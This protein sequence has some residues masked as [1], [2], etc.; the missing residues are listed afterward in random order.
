MRILYVTANDVAGQQFNGYLLH[1]ELLAAGHSSHMAVAWSGFNQPEIH[2]VAGLTLKRI[3]A[4]IANKLSLHSMLS[5]SSTGLYFAP[6]YRNAEI[7]H[8][9]LPHAAQFFSLLNIPLM[10]RRHK[11]VYSLHDPWMMT[12]HCIHPMGC[13]R[14]L[15]GCG[16]CPD[17][18]IP[19]PIRS[20][21]TAFMWRLKHWVMHRAAVNLIVASPWMY[22]RV[23]QSP[24]LSHLPCHLIPLGIDTGSFRPLD[25]T[26]CR[27]KLGIPQDAHVLAFRWAPYF[28]VKGADYIKRAL[29]L[30]EPDRP[31]YL[32]TFDAPAS[33]GLNSLGDKYRY[34]DIGWVEDRQVIV[35]SLN[36]ADLFLMPSIAESFGMMAV[37]AMACGTPVI[38]FE[39]TSL[40]AVVKAPRGGIAVPFKD[41]GALCSAIKMLL[42]DRTR[43]ESL[44]TAGL[45]IVSREY[46]LKAYIQRHFQLYE[47]LVGA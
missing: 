47:S 46:T 27:A 3:D 5:V 39:G 2:E 9:Q 28:V 29:E 12:G 21:H 7:V 45:E 38:V 4:W 36:A 44:T 14:W 41:A 42:K 11:V 43:R 23:Q 22:E 10:S 16:K 34:V 35:D 24:I 37:E 18:G 26:A 30:L 40:P 33:Y 25:K 19:L 31:T 32:L 1:R 20:D 17:L 6:Y 8:L 15:N 13:N